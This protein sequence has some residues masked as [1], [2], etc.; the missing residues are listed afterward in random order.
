MRF[1]INYCL[2]LILENKDNTIDNDSLVK[3]WEGLNIHHKNSR[4]QVEQVNLE[5]SVLS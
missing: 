5:F 1:Y 4:L 2:H 3:V